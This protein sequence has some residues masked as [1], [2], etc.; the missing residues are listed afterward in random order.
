MAAAISFV[1]EAKIRDRRSGMAELRMLRHVRDL[2]TRA[3]HE[4]SGAVLGL[5]S[6]VGFTGEL[7]A[8]ARPGSGVLTAGLDCL[9]GAPS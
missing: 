3:G 1:G 8:A 2:L 7:A 9:Y 5:F 6:T 4:A